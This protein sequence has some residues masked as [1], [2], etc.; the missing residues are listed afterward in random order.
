MR[1]LLPARRKMFG[2]FDKLVSGLGAVFFVV[3]CLES[4]LSVAD[5]YV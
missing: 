3:A 1:R 5:Y 2:R 4:G